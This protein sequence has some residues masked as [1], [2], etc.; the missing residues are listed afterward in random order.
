LSAV[1]KKIL[2][3]ETVVLSNKNVQRDF[4]FV[5]DFVNLIDKVL[6]N[7]PKGYNVYNVGTGKSYSLEE[8]L[9]IIEDIVGKKTILKYDYS[10]RPND[11][12]EMVAN[13]NKVMNEFKWKPTVDIYNGIRIT[14]E[15]YRQAYK[16]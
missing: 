7:F 15:K 6:C 14:I 16:K 8:V 11:I 13:I 5:D 3:D 12:T 4:L 9:K 1:I 10:L 2:N